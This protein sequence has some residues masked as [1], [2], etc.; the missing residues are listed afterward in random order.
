MS[1]TVASKRYETDSKLVDGYFHIYAIGLLIPNDIIKECL[2]FFHIAM[3]WDKYYEWIVNENVIELLDISSVW[4]TIYS[5]PIMSNGYHH[6]KLRMIETPHNMYLGITAINDMFYDGPW[7]DPENRY[8]CMWGNGLSPD[9][10]CNYNST[11]MKSK[12]NYKKDDIISVIISNGKV[13]FSN[14]MQKGDDD[15]KHYEFDIKQEDDIQ[16]YLTVTG[17]AKGTKLELLSYSNNPIYD[18]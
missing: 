11:S 13:S 7:N 8:Y 5:S 18:F 15:I 12:I 9:F 14:S 1:T 2:K 4:A 17:Y 6:W 3:E 16:Y 10:L